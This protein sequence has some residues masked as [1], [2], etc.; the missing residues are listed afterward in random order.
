[1]DPS[2]LAHVVRHKRIVDGRNS[3][4]ADRWRSAGWAYRALGRPNR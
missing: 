1:M 2:A 4:D 3:L